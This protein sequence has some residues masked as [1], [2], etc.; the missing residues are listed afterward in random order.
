MKNIT[1][2]LVLL[3]YK[4]FKTSNGFDF[5]NQIQKAVISI[6]NNMVEG[7]ER[8]SWVNNL[9]NQLVKVSKLLSG[10]IKSL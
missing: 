9:Y 1:N 5:K 8:G 3:I 7:F 10:F 2:D 6:S 4:L